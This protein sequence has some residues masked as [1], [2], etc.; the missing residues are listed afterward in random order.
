M[1]VTKCVV[2]KGK[3]KGKVLLCFNWEPRHEGELG[4]GGIAPVILWSRH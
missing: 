3:G 2:K 4:S 1:M